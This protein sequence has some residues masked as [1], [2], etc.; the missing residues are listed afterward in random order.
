LL[1]HFDAPSASSLLSPHE[2]L[3]VRRRIYGLVVQR[4][5]FVLFVSLW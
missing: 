2:N 1:P 4:E 5:P 3:R